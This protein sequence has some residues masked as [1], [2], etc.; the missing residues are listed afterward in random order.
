MQK[1]PPEWADRPPRPLPLRKCLTP[2]EPA[3]YT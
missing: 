2:H 3:L 1:Q